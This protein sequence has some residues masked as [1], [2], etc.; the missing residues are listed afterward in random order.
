LEGAVNEWGYQL[1]L[2]NH[3]PEAA[4]VFKLNV[5]LHPDSGNAYDSLAEAYMQSGQKDLAIENYK[6]SLEKNPKNEHARDRLKELE[7]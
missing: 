1:V 2:D 5:S 7:K 3:L 4:V 6:M